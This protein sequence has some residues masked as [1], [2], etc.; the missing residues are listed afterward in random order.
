VARDLVIVRG[1]HERLRGAGGSG[2]VEAERAVAFAVGSKR[3]DDGRLAGWFCERDRA[4]GVLRD[5][6]QSGDVAK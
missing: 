2:G 4:A 5:P 6:V 3:A 1:E